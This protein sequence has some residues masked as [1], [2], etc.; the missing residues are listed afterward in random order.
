[1]RKLLVCALFAL[2]LPLA[3]QEPKSEPWIGT[4][5]AEDSRGVG[6]GRLTGAVTFT[7]ARTV[8]G[9][10]NTV[11]GASGTFSGTMDET[12]RVKATM[13]FFGPASVTD[14]KGQKTI[15]STERCQA[16]AKM[17]GQWFSSGILRL[18]TDR[19]KFDTPSQRARQRECEDLRNIVILL[20]THKH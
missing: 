12:G 19:F 14:D 4:L 3:A 16:E 15:I 11:S 2:S 18:T 10:W 8:D 5:E 20:Q 6:V 17:T 9:N 7:D 13:R 1:M